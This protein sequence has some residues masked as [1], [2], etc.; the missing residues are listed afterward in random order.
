MSRNYFKVL[1][2]LLT[3]NNRVFTRSLNTLLANQVVLN[4]QTCRYLTNKSTSHRQ[5]QKNSSI[6]PE[7]IQKFQKLAESWWVENGEFE[8]LHRLNLLRVPLVRDTLVNYR[9]QTLQKCEENEKYSEEQLL[10]EPLLGLNILDVGCG[11]GILS[12]VNY[13]KHRKFI[14]QIKLVREDI[15][16]SIRLNGKFFTYMNGNKIFPNN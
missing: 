4:P 3:T 7:E 2:Q 15:K 14:F 11:G 6:D 9:L 5:S 8:A 16:Y 1:N 13:L 10:R 12:E